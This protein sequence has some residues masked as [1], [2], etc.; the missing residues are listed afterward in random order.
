MSFKPLP[1]NKMIGE[2]LER[3]RCRRA[4]QDVLRQCKETTRKFEGSEETLQ[5]ILRVKETLERLVA[6]LN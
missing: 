5:H 4:F 1:W 6:E 3:F 2:E